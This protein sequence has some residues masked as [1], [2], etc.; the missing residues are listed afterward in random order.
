MPKIN[1][2]F[3][4]N[5]GC[6]DFRIYNRLFRFLSVITG[7]CFTFMENDGFNK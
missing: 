3:H 1:G 5:S 6:F 2:I 4:F 7:G